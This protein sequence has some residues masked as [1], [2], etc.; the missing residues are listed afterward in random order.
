LACT[1]ARQGFNIAVVARKLEPMQALADQ[2]TALGAEARYASVDLSKPDEA[3]ARTRAITDDIE[4]GLLL[5]IAGAN[6]TRGDFLALDPAVYRSVIAIN[7]I[8]QAEFAYH[9]GRLM[10]ARGRGGI[11]LAGSLSSFCG[12]ATVA[13]YTGAKAFSRI[14]TE[15]LWAEC[16]EVDIDVLYVVVG[17]TDTPAMRRFGLDTRTAQSPDEAANQILRS[18]RDGPLL[19]LGGE[20]NSK[21]AAA[22]SQLEGRGRV[23]RQHGTPRRENIPHVAT[24]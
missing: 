8:A 17:Y 19:I 15:S 3:L 10:R 21:L 1:L 12:S 24:R 5:F 2:L 23:V 22:R 14:F 6:E 16:A 4:V 7:V 11:V 13:P 18:L 9:Y 20:T